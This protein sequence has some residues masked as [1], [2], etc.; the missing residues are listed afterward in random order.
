MS[1]DDLP[2]L[3]DEHHLGWADVVRSAVAE[4]EAI[5]RGNDDHSAS[6]RAVVAALGRR[7]LLD[8][9]APK[10]DSSFDLR[11]ICLAREG[12]AWASGNADS[13][14]AVQGL[15]TFPIRSF[16]SEAQQDARLAA[17]R[18]G[19]SVGAF[20]LTEPE[21]GTDAG[22]VQTIARRVDD[23]WI[24]DGDKIFISNAP[25]ADHFV[26]FARLAGEHASKRPPTAAFLVDRP[27]EGLDIVGPTPLVADHVIG[28]V[29][30]RGC[31]VARDA[32]L[33]REGEGF[34]IAMATLDMFRVSVGAAAVG[35]ARRALD[36]AVARA[37]HRHQFGKPIGEF[38]QIQAYLADSLAELDAARLLVY[39]AACLRDRGAASITREAA[40]AKMYATEAAQRIIDRAVQIHGGLGVQR[41]TVVERLYREIRPL[42]IYEGTTEIQRVIIGKGLVHDAIAR[43]PTRER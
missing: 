31:K 24:L 19:R 15:G 3:F 33:G 40:V 8:L 37:A 2:M 11:A 30:L 14:Y 38:Q 35:M 25:I 23:G 27:R 16:G 34:S 20:A 5:E 42:R 17:L 41:G 43:Q 22:S 32:L 28:S 6:A 36:E 12:L 10:A 1:V 9:F 39:R 4:V 13:L 7:G 26:V 21:A 29:S 18:E